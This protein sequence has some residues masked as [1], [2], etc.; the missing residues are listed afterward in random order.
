LYS[1]KETK[2]VSTNEPVSDGDHTIGWKE[3]LPR[4]VQKEIAPI[5]DMKPLKKTRDKEYFQY[6]VKWKG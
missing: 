4:V 3:Q 2:D 5:L 1:F 6:L